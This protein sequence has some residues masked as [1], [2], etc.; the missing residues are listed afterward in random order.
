M[1]PDFKDGAKRREGGGFDEADSFLGNTNF[2]ALSECR[3]KVAEKL[4]QFPD[5]HFHLYLINAGKFAAADLPLGYRVGVKKKKT[6]TMT[7]Q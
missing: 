3:R 5:L 1:T 4:V 6:C 2:T 7:R